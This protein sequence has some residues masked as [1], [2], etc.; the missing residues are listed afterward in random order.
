MHRAKARPAVTRQTT[1]PQPTKRAR[2]PQTISREADPVDDEGAP[3]PVVDDHGGI[4]G[5]LGLD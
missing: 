5:D 2:V 1:Q 3:L 4:A